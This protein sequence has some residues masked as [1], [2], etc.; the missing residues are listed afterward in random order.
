MASLRKRPKSDFW[1][2]CYTSSDGRR[3]QRST[4]T[5]DKDQA[6]MVCRQWE[7]E[8][9]MEREELEAA[10]MDSGHG[11]GRRLIWA[12]AAIAVLLQIGALLWSASTTVK[13]IPRLPNDDRESVWPSVD[14]DAVQAIFLA[15]AFAVL[16]SRNRGAM[17][18]KVNDSSLLEGRS[19]WS[20][21]NAPVADML[22]NLAT[23]STKGSDFDTIMKVEWIGG[24]EIK[25]KSKTGP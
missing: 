3:T 25:D 15:R 18:E 4:G 5:A 23:F 9:R 20:R 16:D 1:V 12:A 8:A 13:P 2:C 14:E 10:A 17:P 11:K 22:K 24:C 6:M 7:G 21:W 19:V